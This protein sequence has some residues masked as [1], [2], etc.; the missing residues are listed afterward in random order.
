MYVLDKL[1]RGTLSPSEQ[2]VNHGSEYSNLH[3]RAA[4]MGSQIFT[5][6]SEEE[7]RLF[8]EYQELRERMSYISEEDQFING[9]RMGIGLI[10]DAIGTYE[11]QFVRCQED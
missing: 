8:Q 11:S 5:R 2:C 10:L 4:Q 6:M 3:H 7:K 9:F 1:W